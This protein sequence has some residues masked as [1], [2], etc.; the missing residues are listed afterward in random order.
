MSVPL[1][2]PIAFDVG[3]LPRHVADAVWRGSDLGSSI[4]RTVSS[5]FDAL[6]R[7]LPG[8]GWPTHGLTELL[9]PQSA[10]CEWRLISPAIPDFLAEGGRV[11]LVAPPKEPHAAGLAQLGVAPH[12]VVWIKAAKP[13]DRLWVTEQLLKS[14][15]AGLV[16]AWLPQARPEQIRRLQIHAQTCDCPVMLLRPITALNDTSPAPLRV[17]V[18]LAGGWGLEVRIP[19][20]RGASLDGPVVVNATPTNLMQ[21]LPPR[22]KNLQ[23]LPAAVPREEAADA[24][25]LGSTAPSIRHVQHVSH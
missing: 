9:L 1:R 2:A 16:M 24:W 8:G 21:V 12:Q 18:A 17:S 10:L 7:E 15:P 14:D 23:P 6:D 22:L 3:A 19:K 5:G 11:Y 4:A 20:R 13:V 25:A